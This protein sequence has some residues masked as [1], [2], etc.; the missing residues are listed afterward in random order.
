MFYP[1]HLLLGQQ[2]LD[3]LVYYLDYQQFECEVYESI[4]YSQEVL[5]PN[6]YLS[7]FDFVYFEYS[8]ISLLLIDR[9]YW[10]SNRMEK[11]AY[12]RCR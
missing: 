9:G 7:Y 10:G 11:W 5:L 1:N 8:H 4:T 6:K 3:N 2:I 12:A